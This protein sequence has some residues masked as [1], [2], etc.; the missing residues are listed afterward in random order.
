M[1]TACF[2]VGR[3]PVAQSFYDS[4]IRSE[5]CR[6]E[7]AVASAGAGECECECECDF[8]FAVAGNGP[9]YRV[10]QHPYMQSSY[11]INEGAPDPG[12]LPYRYLLKAIMPVAFI[13]LSV[14][15]FAMLG[16]ALTRLTRPS[17]VSN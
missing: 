4:P 10:A 5:L 15:A 3:G 9:D 12:G 16:A 17:Q 14:R 6:H 13:L 11:S 1:K 2:W 7:N 8:N